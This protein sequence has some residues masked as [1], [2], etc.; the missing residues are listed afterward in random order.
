MLLRVLAV[1]ALVLTISP[2][3]AQSDSSMLIG[4]DTLTYR[5]VPV[6][7]IPIRG[8][9][10]DGASGRSILDYLTFGDDDPNP[11]VSFTVIGSPYYTEER[12]WG[13]ALAGDMRYRTKRMSR[14]DSPSLLRLKL[15]ASLKAYYSAQ[16]MGENWLGGNRHRVRYEASFASMPGYVWGLNFN[17]ATSGRRGGYNSENI[18]VAGSYAHRLASDLMVGVHAD[19]R[20]MVAC[21]LS[22]YA[23]KVL[24]GE[25][26]SLAALGVGVDIE[27]D[28]RRADATTMRGLYFVGA[29]TLRHYL[30]DDIPMGH[31]VTLQ[32]D[33]YLPLWRGATLLFD[34]YGE[35]NSAET[36]WMLRAKLGGDVRMRGYYWGRYIGDNMVA[37]QVELSQHVWQGL[38]LAAWGGAGTLFS[39][40]D[41]FAW[42]K[43]LPTYGLGLRWRLGS[44]GALKIDVAFGRGSN[45]VIA[46]FSGV[47]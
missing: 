22:D 11:G 3:Y 26:L 45:A 15:S 8:E 47:F 20:H 14:E 19:Y 18:I 16:L 2:T 32:L 5:Y 27:Y 40:D 10:S 6:D 28:A 44:E 34:L 25:V 7:R 1:V 9:P 31:N 4:G 43:V 29:Y 41:S 35:Y 12:G 38:A 33:Y 46:G 17:E 24:S 13:I 39:C 42:R 23:A 30:F 36:P 37:T 21:D